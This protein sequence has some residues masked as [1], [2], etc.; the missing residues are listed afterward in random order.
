MARVA[1]RRASGENG[2][3]S[4]KRLQRGL[5]LGLAQGLPVAAGALV[6]EVGQVGVLRR[7]QPVLPGFGFRPRS[8]ELL[9]WGRF[10]AR[11][12][13]HCEYPGNGAVLEPAAGQVAE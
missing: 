9:E 6:A 4:R 10:P 7:E 12:E 8:G 13:L 3:D 1:A 5:R 2:S 11:P